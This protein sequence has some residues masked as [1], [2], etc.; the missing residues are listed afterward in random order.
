MLPVSDLWVRLSAGDLIP[1]KLQP[2]TSHHSCVPGPARGGNIIL[3]ADGHDEIEHNRERIVL[4]FLFALCLFFVGCTHLPFRP[5]NFFFSPIKEFVNN[6]QVQQYAP[7]DVYFKSP[8]GLTLHGWYLRAKEEKGTILIC[9]GYAKNISM[10]MNDDLWLIAAG[11]NLFMFDYRGYGKSQGTSSI[12]GVQ[13]D[14]EAALETLLFALPRAKQ[15]SILVFGKSIGGAIAVYAI[16]NSP[17]KDRVKALIV[18]STF[19]SYRKFAQEMIAGSVIGWPFQYPLSLLVNDD[20]SPVKWI[21]A[22]SPVSVVII[23]GN[24]DESAPIH[25]G[26]ILYGAA[27]P[28]KKFW[29]SSI[30]GHVVAHVD[31]EI[32]EKLLAFFESLPASPILDPEP[33]SANTLCP[34]TMHN[35]EK[36]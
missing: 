32:K 10:H 15:D 27:L 16:A 23:H 2:E 33:E 12:G 35:P 9:H 21:K 14:A 20:Y 13:L 24:Q 11:Y 6:P 28:P 31:E 1:T 3:A 19:S 26:R 5:I 18:D 7:Q 36:K 8:D 34:E 29:E 30:P 17:Y 22:V 25:H 4:S